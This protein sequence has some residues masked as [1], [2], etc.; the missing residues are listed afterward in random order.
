MAFFKKRPGALTAIGILFAIA[1]AGIAFRVM[2]L[3]PKRLPY[4]DKVWLLSCEFQFRPTEKNTVVFV[5]L[6]VDT[7]HAKVL[8]QN[9]YYPGLRQARLKDKKD[10]LR[11]AAFVAPL[12]GDY[13]LRAEFQ[14]H[15]G[16]TAN[17]LRE[18]KNN[19]LSAENRDLYLGAGPHIQIDSP[20]II[21]A[22]QPF[23]EESEQSRLPERIAD[24]CEQKIARGPKDSPADAAEALTRRKAAGIGR[25]RA[26]VALFRIA[27]IPARLICGFVLSE[28]PQA[29]THFWVEAYVDKNWAPFDPEN[30]YRFTLPDHFIA[31][32]RGGSEILRI[33]GGALRSQKYAI[34]HIVT[35]PG[36]EAIGAKNPLRILDLSRLPVANQNALVM[37]LMLPVGALVTTF[38]RNVV[39]IR[40]FGTFTPTLLALATV[41]TDWQTAVLIFIVVVAIGIG[42][43]ALLPNLKLMRVPRLSVVFTLVAM[44]MTLTVSALDYIHFTPVG[45]V[46]LLPLVILTTIIDR[47][48]YP[49]RRKRHA[50]CD[51]PSGLDHRSCICMFPA[52]SVA[53]LGTPVALLSG[54]AFCHPGADRVAGP[55]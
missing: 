22:F 29:Q 49:G 12:P 43:R 23:L 42:G 13:F 48:L 15:A 47:V 40:T 38:V 21:A 35:P 28:T 39:G 19:P 16:P 25:A 24:F 5:P 51:G 17:R 20:A 7:V 50:Y 10:D 55:L 11:E 8:G 33:P 9:F 32:R 45:H 37:L 54:T 3:N 30:G 41:Y 26:M 31:L 44:I 46:V 36:F 27:K 2:W 4:G 1:I 6:P 34:T 52:F 18:I 53:T 14:I